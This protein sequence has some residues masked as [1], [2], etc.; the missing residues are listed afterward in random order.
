MS[1]HFNYTK[2]ILEITKHTWTFFNVFFLI[3]YTIAVIGNQRASI[4]KNLD[5]KFYIIAGLILFVSILLNLLWILN[6]KPF[7]QN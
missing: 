3:L 4:T 2:F 5:T 7:K 1:G 6:K